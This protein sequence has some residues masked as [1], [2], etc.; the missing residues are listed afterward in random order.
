M[1]L[2]PDD[3]GLDLGDAPPLLPDEGQEVLGLPY[4]DVLGDVFGDHLADQEWLERN[5]ADI[6]VEDSSDYY[7]GALIP[8]LPADDFGGMD[9]CEVCE[10]VA[11]PD[12]MSRLTCAC[13]HKCVERVMQGAESL[14]RHLRDE[15]RDKHFLLE[16]VKHAHLAREPRYQAQVEDCKTQCLQ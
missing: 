6:S 11:L 5:L 16:L 9:I 8:G 12:N 3:R 4:D 10:A 14:A 7:Y 13:Q 1:Q 15:V 2:P